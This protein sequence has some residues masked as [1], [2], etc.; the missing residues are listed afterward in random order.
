VRRS[1]RSVRETDSSEPSE[2]PSAVSA[3]YISGMRQIE[4]PGQQHDWRDR[5]ERVEAQWADDLHHPRPQTCLDTLV[6]YPLAGNF[7]PA[8][9]NARVPACRTPRSR[10]MLRA[11]RIRNALVG[12][13]LPFSGDSKRSLVPWRSDGDVAAQLRN[14]ANHRGCSASGFCCRHPWPS[15]H[16]AGPTSEDQKG[17]P[18]PQARGNQPM[19]SVSRADTSWTV[20]RRS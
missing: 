14:A 19:P 4:S 18:T 17:Y 2:K 3:E 7:R 8:S 1:I 13:P 9:H 12:C 15:G 6:D 5:G 10:I 16:P 11:G 20:G